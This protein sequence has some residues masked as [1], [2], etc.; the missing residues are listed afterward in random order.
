MFHTGIRPA[1][2]KVKLS[3]IDLCKDCIIIKV[4]LKNKTTRIVPINQY[5][6]MIFESMQ[7][8]SFQMIIIYLA[9]TKK[10]YKAKKNIVNNYSPAPYK[11]SEKKHLIYGN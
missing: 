11:R 9:L 2:L 1:E 8:D 4:Y 7:L 10:K 6:K 3:M 5:Q